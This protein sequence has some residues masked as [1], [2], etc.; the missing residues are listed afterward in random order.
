M[1]LPLSVVVEFRSMLI[2]GGQWPIS[3]Q[4]PVV[5]LP[6]IPGICKFSLFLILEQLSL[7]W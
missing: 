5:R 2:P 6:K 7:G 1:S 3:L 4:I